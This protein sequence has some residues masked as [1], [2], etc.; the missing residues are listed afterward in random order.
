M[1]KCFFLC[2]IFSLGLFA[3]APSLKTQP[4]HRAL[5]ICF[6]GKIDNA[7]SCSVTTGSQ[8]GAG[9]LTCGHEGKNSTISWTFEGTEGTADVYRFECQF[10]ATKVGAI[11]GISKRIKF[12]G[13]RIIVFEDEHVAVVMDPDVT[14]KKINRTNL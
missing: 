2:S 11:A 1:K 14:P 12:A 4:Q 3:A 10:P 9:G 7:P 5:V 8:G 13:R 6:D